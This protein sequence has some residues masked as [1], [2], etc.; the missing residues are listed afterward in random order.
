VRL[1]EWNLQTSR[2]CDS[3]TNRGTVCSP[4]PIDMT[5]ARKIVHE[6][7][8]P[9]SKNQNNDIAL[10]RLNGAVEFSDFIRPICLPST[11][12]D[13]TD[14]QMVV[15]G[16]GKTE[17]AGHS[18]LKLKTEIRGISNVACQNFYNIESLTVFPTQICAL[19]E[20]GKDSW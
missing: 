11:S 3:S 2:D 10:L 6:N 16:F 4:A 8:V 17:Y 12:E 1:G 14:V 15:A 5:I 19:G 20:L 9:F 13:L 7:Y 18:D